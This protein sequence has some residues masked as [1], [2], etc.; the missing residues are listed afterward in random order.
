M[1]FF[2]YQTEKTEGFTADPNPKILFLGTCGKIWGGRGKR[3][4]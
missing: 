4:F 2:N 1:D 3:L